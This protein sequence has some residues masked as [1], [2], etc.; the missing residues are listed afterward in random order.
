M[1]VAAPK[2]GPVM[3]LEATNQIRAGSSSNECG[4]KR[5]YKCKLDYYPYTTQRHIILT[6]YTDIDNVESQPLKRSLTSKK[7]SNHP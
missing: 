7:M 6:N 3:M 1:L 4:S 2:D 5:S